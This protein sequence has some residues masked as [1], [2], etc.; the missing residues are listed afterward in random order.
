MLA[1]SVQIKCNIC[2]TTI[3][4]TLKIKKIFN[5]NLIKKCQLIILPKQFHTNIWSTATHPCYL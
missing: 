2:K 1:E 4:S 3:F 5:N